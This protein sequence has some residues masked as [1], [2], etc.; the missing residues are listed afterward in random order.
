VYNARY[1]QQRRGFEEE[2][3]S[4]ETE[5]CNFSTDRS[6]FPTEEIVEFQFCP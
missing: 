2:E 4:R 3:E 5:S 1:A 6:R